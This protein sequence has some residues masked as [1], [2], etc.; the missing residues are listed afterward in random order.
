MTKLQ[1]K[2]LIGHISRFPDLKENEDFS[3]Y[4][5]LK[6]NKIKE[7]SMIFFSLRTIV[8]CLIPEE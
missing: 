7:K 5:I 8:K 3:E 2:V 4:M 1:G 6:I